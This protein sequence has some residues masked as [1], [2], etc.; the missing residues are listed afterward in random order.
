MADVL[1]ANYCSPKY[2]QDY[3]DFIELLAEKYPDILKANTKQSKHIR[4]FYLNKDPRKLGGRAVGPPGT[5]GSNNGGEGKG[6]YVK[7]KQVDVTKN[8]STQEK[9]SPLYP[10]LAL[11]IDLNGSDRADKFQSKP[12]QEKDDYDMCRS[13]ASHDLDSANLGSNLL[14][15]VCT[16]PEWKE[17]SLD[18]RI[19]AVELRD[20]RFILDPLSVLGRHDV[21]FTAHLPNGRATYPI[22]REQRKELGRVLS[23]A[24]Y[25]ERKKI[26]NPGDDVDTPQKCQ[27]IMADLPSAGKE[28]LLNAHMANLAENIPGKKVGESFDQMVRRRFQRNP[29]EPGKMS[30]RMKRLITE[31]KKRMTKKSKRD[32]KNDKEAEVAKYGKS[33][34]E[35]IEGMSIG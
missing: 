16:S 30:T 26:I 31:K 9:K 21:S 24:P 19:Q 25:R 28:A 8:L 29:R 1:K 35:T 10:M 4:S 12:I 13:T 11:G 3:Q 14:Y 18:E 23:S 15:M 7:K 17:L 20:P 6:K 34:I 33:E 2:P 22:V 32:S 27:A 5:S